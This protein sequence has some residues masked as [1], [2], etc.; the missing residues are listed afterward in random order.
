MDEQAVFQSLDLYNGPIIA[1]HANAQAWFAVLPQPLF[2]GSRDPRNYQSRWCHRHCSLQSFSG[3]GMDIPTRQTCSKIRGCGN[4]NRPHMPAGR[5]CAAC[6][7]SAVIL[8]A[9]WV[10]NQPHQRSIRLPTC[11][12]WHPC[13]NPR[14][15][16]RP[17]MLPI[18]WVETGSDNF[19]D[20]YL[21]H[22]TQKTKIHP[23]RN[24]LPANQW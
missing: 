11:K 13:L 7:A 10:C 17:W 23:T 5:G 24:T 18:F 14:G 16:L 8:M 3:L 22:A 2:K 4:P 1:S 12:N 9:E 6:R 19:I 20:H 15:Y 21:D